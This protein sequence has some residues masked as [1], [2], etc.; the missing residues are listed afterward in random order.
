[1]AVRLGDARKASKFAIKEMTLR[2]VWEMIQ[3]H[4]EEELKDSPHQPVDTSMN[5]RSLE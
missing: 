2:S 3:R 1:L 5:L 4:I